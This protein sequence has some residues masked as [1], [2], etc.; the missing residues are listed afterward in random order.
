MNCQ[1]DCQ[2]PFD[3]SFDIAWKQCISWVSKISDS[4]TEENKLPIS[5]KNLSQKS[6]GTAPVARTSSQCQHASVEA[7]IKAI[8]AE[9]WQ[10]PTSPNGQDAK[11]SGANRTI[12]FEDAN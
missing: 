7:G 3:P 4:H 6:R 10:K 8:G 11:H 9:E 1:L 2:A 5:R 12:P